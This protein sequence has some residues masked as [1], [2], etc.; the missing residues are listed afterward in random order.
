MGGG[1]H[2]KHAGTAKA[3]SGFASKF[4][5]ASNAGGAGQWMHQPT[6][7]GISKAYDPNPLRP[8]I[9]NNKPY[10]AAQFFNTG[11]IKVKN[12]DPNKGV[13]RGEK[14]MARGV[15]FLAGLAR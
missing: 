6:C 13:T 12:V 9:T 8:G 1:G 4:N 2:A 11:A 10:D 7:D 15:G 3:T 14:M 5:E